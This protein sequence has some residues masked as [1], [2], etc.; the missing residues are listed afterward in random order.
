MLK[1]FAPVA[2]SAFLVCACSSSSTSSSSGDGTDG[3]GGGGGGSLDAGPNDGSCVATASGGQTGTYSCAVGGS[4]SPTDYT[5][6][7]ID[8][9]TTVAAS[10][11]NVSAIFTFQGAPAVKTYTVE[12]ADAVIDL[13]SG[14]PRSIQWE[15]QS[16]KGAAIEGTFTLT[17][18]DA[19]QTMDLGSSG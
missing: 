12:T 1:A 4:G 9:Q 11:V 2:V 8:D 18:T 10:D 13:Y 19:G 14:S 17:I 6:L 3:G 5:T 15:A 7:N 16:A